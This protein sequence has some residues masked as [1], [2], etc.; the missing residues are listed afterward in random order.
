MEIYEKIFTRLE[1]LHMTQL[2]LSRRTGI[3]TSTICDWKKKMINPQSD[4]LVSIC[5]ALEMSLV[6]LLCSDDDLDSEKRL[7]RYYE[8]VSDYGKNDDCKS[9]VDK[10]KV[11]III[12]ENGNQI[13][14]VN[15]KKFKGLSK[16]DWREVEEYLK[17]YVGEYYEIACCADKIFID[18]DFPDEYSN[19][20]SR[21]VFIILWHRKNV[22][23]RNRKIHFIRLR[24]SRKY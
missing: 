23:P 17:Q 20:E 19:S 13:V 6:D 7:L 3:A 11:S 21:L 8:L 22:N 15:D 18:T 24:F 1:K 16:G 14:L 9:C 10:R 2:E 12:D 5:K 4:K